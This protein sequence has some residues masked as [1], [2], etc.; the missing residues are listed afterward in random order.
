MVTPAAAHFIKDTK[1]PTNTHSDSQAQPSDWVM[2]WAYLIK[3]A[4]QSEKSKG[5]LQAQAQA[6]DQANLDADVLDL[7]CGNGRHMR[8]LHEQGLRVLGVDK[9]SEA[10][11]RCRSDGQ[12][13]MADLESATGSDG[14]VSWPLNQ[15]QF[16]A[17]IVTNYLWRPLFPYI[18][19][20]LKDNGVLIYET[21]ALGNELIGRPSRPDFLLKQGEL[22][23]ICTNL[24]VVAYEEV[25]LSQPDRFVQRIVAIRGPKEVSGIERY[26]PTSR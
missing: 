8:W 17:V 3:H 9:D 7:A 14:N 16:N 18:L 2:R 19:N 4:P 12:V 6:H 23:Q 26:R 13:V 5:V 22:L 10:L 24:R 21:F 25:L 1:I 15:S 11:A 20:A